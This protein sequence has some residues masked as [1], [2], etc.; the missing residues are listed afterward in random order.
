MF[1]EAHFNLSNQKNRRKLDRLLEHVNHA[2]VFISMNA[3]DRVIRGLNIE[4]GTGADN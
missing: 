2:D 1:C 4:E 3:E